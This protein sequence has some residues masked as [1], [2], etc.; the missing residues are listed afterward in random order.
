MRLRIVLPKVNPEAITVPT[1]CAYADC[2][3]RKFHLRQEVGE[4]A[5]RHGVSGGAGASLS[6]FEVPTHLP[7][8]SRGNQPSTD[9][10]ARERA[11]GD[12]VSAGVELWSRLL[13][14]RRAWDLT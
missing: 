3:G 12:A 14:L 11:R 8:L 5:A 4:T 13:S 10:A 7:G 1:R 2:G 9:L 6:V